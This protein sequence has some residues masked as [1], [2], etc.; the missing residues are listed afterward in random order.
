MTLAR[1]RPKASRS[2]AQCTWSRRGGGQPCLRRRPQGGPFSSADA[3]PASRALG[4]EV[5]G[6]HFARKAVE[7]QNTRVLRPGCSLAAP[8][9]HLKSR[10]EGD[11]V[12]LLGHSQQ[13]I[14]VAT[15]EGTAWSSW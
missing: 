3:A 14:A 9:Q 1:Q 7:Q 15:T 13:R 10:N 8:A 11:G 12:T 5:Y 4:P 2:Y 6:A